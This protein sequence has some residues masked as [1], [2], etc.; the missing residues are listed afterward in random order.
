MPLPAVLLFRAA[1]EEWL[2]PWQDEHRG[3]RS[4]LTIMQD[5]RQKD[6]CPPLAFILPR[7]TNHSETAF[8]S[9]GRAK[10][11]ELIRDR[12]GLGTCQMDAF[13]DLELIPRALDSGLI[14]N[15]LAIDGFSL[16][17]AAAVYHALRRPE[18]FVSLGSFDGAFLD[19]NFDNPLL[20]PQTPSD[21]RLDWFPYLYGFP[22]DEA[23]FRQQSILEHPSFKLPPAMIHYARAEHPT[24]NNWRVK[25][26]LQ[27]SGLDN[28]AACPW[29]SP[30]S[31]HN[32]YWAD[33]HLYRSLP[34]H[35][36]HL[37]AP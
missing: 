28:Q 2:R 15:R 19:W 9:Y 37:Y 4:L 18:R 14:Q 10:A 27:L 24:A 25:K 16:G 32:W 11:P 35:A 31:E 13:L 12:N 8:V 22:P 5:L 33:E 26:F 1:P 21:L 3:G 30:H 23:L 29:M 34:F 17:G 20:N 36:R 7:T 6:L